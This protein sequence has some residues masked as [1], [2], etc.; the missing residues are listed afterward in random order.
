MAQ[1]IFKS[2]K[3]GIEFSVKITAN[4]KQNKIADLYLD[5]KGNCFLKISVTST[6]IEGKANAALIN[7]LADSWQLKKTQVK[8]K[9]GSTNRYKIIHI[10]G[11]PESLLA[12]LNNYL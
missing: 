1:N 3:D 5:E 7:L 8:I 9:H 12:H 10:E 6:A 2:Q 4:A 11:N